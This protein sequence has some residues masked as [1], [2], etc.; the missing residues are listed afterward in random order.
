MLTQMKTS[1]K[2]EYVKVELI[3]RNEENPRILFRQSEMER[4]MDSIGSYG[5]QVPVSVYRDGRRFVLIDGERRWRCALKLGLKTL[6]S[7]IQSKPSRLDNLLLMF[8]I[9]ALRE[10]WDY[11]TIAMKLQPLID[12]LQREGPVKVPSERD[13]SIRTGLSRATIR[14]CRYLLA[15]PEKYREVILREL[16]KPKSQQKLTEDFFIEMERSLTAVQKSMPELLQDE[17]EK[18]AIRQVLIDKYKRDI[19]PSRIHF[20]K[21]ARIA[22]ADKVAVERNKAQRVLTRLFEKNDY[23]IEKAYDDSV[24][25]AYME[26]DLVTR[27]ESLL[28]GLRS[29]DPADMD[30]NLREHLRQL[31][32]EAT[33]ILE[34]PQ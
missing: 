17:H 11:M 2:L 30:D 34:Q 25:E 16:A 28:E 12:L 33:T 5:I 1:E 21:I 8:N 7:L 18:E 10:Q 23:S 31:I 6:P 9:H 15:L 3:D 32:Q 4:L 24:S 13:I 22:R 14:R 20:R 29:F 19:I 26:R 27:I